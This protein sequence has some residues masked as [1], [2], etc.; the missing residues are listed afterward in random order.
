MIEINL[1]PNTGKK[2]KASPGKSLDL[3]ALAG[4]FSGKLRDKFLIGTIVS[5]V[6]GGAALG[7]LYTTQTARAAEL[8]ERREN[9]VKDSTRY[10]TLLK[11]RHRAESVRDTLLREVNVI[12]TLDDDRFI[13]PHVL[14]EVSRALPQYTWLTNLTFTGSPQGSNNVVAAPKGDTAAKG[15]NLQQ[16][17]RPT[18]LQRFQHDPI[19]Q[20]KDR[21]VRPDS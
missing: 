2:K 7:L 6:A 9:A 13:W 21:S 8:T 11:D 10:A 14:D 1:N 19:H 12:R 18:N 16:L 17:C 3:G 15:K 5:V 20:S 4:G